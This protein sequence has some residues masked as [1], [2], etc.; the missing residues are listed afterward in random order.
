MILAAP[1][2]RTTLTEALQ[3]FETQA[4]RD[5]AELG[6]YRCRYAVWGDGPPLIF[7]HGLGDNLSSSLLAMALLRQKF[8]CIA[9]DQPTGVDDGCRLTTYTHD[10]LAGDLLS[11]MDHL[12]LR[13]A[14]VLGHSFGST[15][16]A[17][18]MVAAPERIPRAVMVGGFAKRP[19]AWGEWFLCRLLKRCPGATR[20]VPLRLTALERSHAAPFALCEPERWKFFLE[21]SGSVPIRVLTHWALELH[22]TDIRPLLPQ[23]AQPVLLVCGDRDPL[24]PHEHQQYLFTHLRNAVMFQITDCGHFPALTH[25][26]ALAGAVERFLL[27][28]DCVFQ[29]PQHAPAGCPAACA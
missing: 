11:L 18:A 28:P 9:Y 21:Q 27:A 22:R 8:R 15:V 3:D 13:R 25:P 16:A 10:Q 29:A 12:G 2:S 19:L 26:E 7:V 6:R 23:I 20:Q 1:E 17:K 14:A 24:V 4:H 5:I